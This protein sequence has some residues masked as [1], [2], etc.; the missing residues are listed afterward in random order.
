MRKALTWSSHLLIT[1]TLAVA[2]ALALQFF[3]MATA[4]VG[5]S[6]EQAQAALRTLL[7]GPAMSPPAG[8]VPNF[9]DPAN[10]DIYVTLTITLGVAFSS[11]AVILRMY[12]KVF[13]LRVLAWEDCWFYFL[14]HDIAAVYLLLPL[15]CHCPC[16]GTSACKNSLISY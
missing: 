15:R 1:L 6:P 9:D 2:L 10:L 5:M 3:K 7:E 4:T 11:V 12:T 8:V 14:S 13:I 16:M